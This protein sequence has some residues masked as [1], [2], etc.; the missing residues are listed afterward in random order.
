MTTTFT[1][2]LFTLSETKYEDGEEYVL[3]DD[4]GRYHKVYYTGAYRKDANPYIIINNH[5]YHLG[6]FIKVGY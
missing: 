4:T 1:N 2:G 3:L 6:D 5:R